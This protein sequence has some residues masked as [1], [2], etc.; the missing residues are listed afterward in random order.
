MGLNLFSCG[1]KSYCLSCIYPKF[2]NFIAILSLWYWGPPI[3]SH[4][5]HPLQTALST[6][7]SK[8]S[9][10]WLIIKTKQWLFL[11]PWYIHCNL[12]VKA[13]VTSW[14]TMLTHFSKLLMQG[15]TC[16]L[17]TAWVVNVKSKPKIAIKTQ[18]KEWEREQVNQDENIATHKTKYHVRYVNRPEAMHGMSLLLPSVD[19]ILRGKDW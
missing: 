5:P 7:L 15:E 16:N 12:S 19:T 18:I 2:I 11:L 17:Y 8:T 1:A 9:R 3:R 14:I 10:I 6:Q 13:L 4:Y